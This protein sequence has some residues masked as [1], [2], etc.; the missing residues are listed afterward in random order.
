MKLYAFPSHTTKERTSGVDYARVIQPA[1]ALKDT[2]T[3]RIFDTSTKDNWVDIGKEYDAIF[4]NYLNN[5]WGYATMACYN[6]M[7]KH[8]IV[9]DVDDDLWD[10]L[11]DNTAYEVYHKGTKA[12]KNFTLICKDVDAVITTNSYLRNVINFNTGVPL[13]KIHVIPNYINLEVYNT[14]P[15]PRHQPNVVIGH[16]GSTT[17]FNS[18]LNEDFIKG[19][20]MVMK[21]FPNVI[22][23]TIGSFIP[24]FKDKW[25]ARYENAFGDPDIYKWAKKMP[26]MLADIDFMVT[27]LVDNLYN[28]CKSSIKWLEASSAKRVGCW[29]AIR[30]YQEVIDG[31][32]GF[33]CNSPDSWYNCMKVLIEDKE[34]RDEMAETAYNQVKK[35]WTIQGNVNRYEKLFKDLT[36]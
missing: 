31:D 24:L 16:M 4:F 22:F 10:V 26:E 20:D 14:A 12:L 5:D 35:D 32:N 29:Q 9:L 19:M 27:P 15:K 13:D 2:F 25:G 36:S 23:R 1:Q 33:L 8:K 6:R 11:P 7:H 21:Q 34:R 30:Q 3:V 28:R 18:L 17:H